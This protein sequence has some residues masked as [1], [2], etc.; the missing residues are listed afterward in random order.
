MTYEIG[1][2]VYISN[3]GRGVSVNKGKIVKISPTGV[4]RVNVVSRNGVDKFPMTFNPNGR[5]RGT[6][7]SW[8]GGAWLVNREDYESLLER[9][10]EEANRRAVY[11]A[12]KEFDGK[13]VNASNKENLLKLATKLTNAINKL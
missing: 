8:S 2:E 9:S 11:L 3:G 6:A 12:I 1:Q 5:E 13:L 4:M 7:G 10:N